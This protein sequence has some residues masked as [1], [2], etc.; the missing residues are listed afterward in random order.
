ME[1]YLLNLSFL[2]LIASSSSWS[3][4][5][6]ILQVHTTAKGIYNKS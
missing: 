5:S 1:R 3:N 2:S 4:K 6:E